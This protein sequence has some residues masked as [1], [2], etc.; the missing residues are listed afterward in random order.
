MARRPS[1]RHA[2]ERPACP[3]D[4]PAGLTDTERQIG[5]VRGSS[6]VI[7][8]GTARRAPPGAAPEGANP[9]AM[10][11]PVLFA[12]RGQLTNSENH[13]LSSDPQSRASRTDP[14]V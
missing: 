11:A 7:P 5:R 3:Q 14:D 10:V 12:S 4:R 8:T 6:G 2:G 1:V 9:R 13:P